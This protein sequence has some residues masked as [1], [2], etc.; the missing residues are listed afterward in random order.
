MLP[1]NMFVD[2]EDVHY[3]CDSIFEFYR[4]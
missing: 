3:V 1:I 4:S 2:D